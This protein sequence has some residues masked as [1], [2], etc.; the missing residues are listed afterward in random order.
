M[1]RS[2]KLSRRC[3]AGLL[4]SLATV[5][6]ALKWMR[7]HNPA[8]AG[9]APIHA[10]QEDVGIA[11]GYRLPPVGCIRLTIEIDNEGFYA[12]RPHVGILD[13]AR[14]TNTSVKRKLGDLHFRANPLVP[15]K[16]PSVVVDT[17]W[18]LLFH[19]EWGGSHAVLIGKAPIAFGA[20][21]PVICG[22]YTR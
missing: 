20:R 17:E 3:C 19:T 15:F 18:N 2:T 9:D 16:V 6:Q 4:S 1:K 7:E 8:L 11:L 5:E 12:R 13:E 22:S 10:I 14:R 21:N